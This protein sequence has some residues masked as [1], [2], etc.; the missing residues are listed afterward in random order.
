MNRVVVLLV[1]AFL[2]ISVRADDKAPLIQLHYVERPPYINQTGSWLE[3]LTATPALDAFTRAGVPFILRSTPTNRQ[4]LLIQNNEG[5]DCAIGWF[6]SSDRE[7]FARFSKPLHLTRGWAVITHKSFPTGTQSF[8]ELM[9]NKNNRVL[10]RDKFIYGEYITER[11]KALRPTSFITTVE[12]PQ[13]LQM[14]QARR[15][16]FMFAS[17]EEAEL[18]VKDR[19]ELKLYFPPDSPKTGSYRHL[20]CSKKVPTEVIEKLNAQLRLI[21]P[22]PQN[23]KPL[24]VSK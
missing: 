4:L 9:S 12:M 23:P 24:F 19:P 16:D 22:Y 17:A 15:S 3:G 14:I 8:T 21:A 18:A 13:M 7:K 20:I 10:L 2:G 1:V 5:Y 6:K 11:V